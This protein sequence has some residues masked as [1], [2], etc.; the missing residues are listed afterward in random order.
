[1]MVI[2]IVEMVAH[3]CVKNSLIGYAQVVLLILKTNV[4]N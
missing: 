1:M 2:T 4:K 3:K